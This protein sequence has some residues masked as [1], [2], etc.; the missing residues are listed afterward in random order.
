MDMDG[1]PPGRQH[2]VEIHPLL[3]P[4]G[5]EMPVGVAGLS[6]RRV[7]QLPLHPSDVGACLEEPGGVAMPHRAGLPVRQLGFRY[8]SS[9]SRGRQTCSENAP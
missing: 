4:F 5:L 9:W 1:P 7:P 2:L 3:V 6:D 8:G